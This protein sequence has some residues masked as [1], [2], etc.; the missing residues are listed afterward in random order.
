LVNKDKHYV[1]KCVSDLRR[2]LS[3]G[4][5]VSSTN[6]TDPKRYNRNIVEGGVKRHKPIY[7]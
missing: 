4:T 2:W 5:P 1:I 3:P 6:K 7:Q